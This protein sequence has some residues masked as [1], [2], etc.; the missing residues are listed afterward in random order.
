[1]PTENDRTDP[2]AKV[3]C[4][5]CGKSQDEVRKI[6]A[7]P[8]VYICDECINLCNDVMEVEAGTAAG[9]QRDDPKYSPEPT[10]ATKSTIWSLKRWVRSRRDPMPP[11][12]DAGQD[13]KEIQS[14]V[15]GLCGEPAP[16]ADV[17]L[18]RDRWLMCPTC[19][20]DVRKLILGE[21]SEEAATAWLAQA[22][23]DLAAARHMAAH[24]NWSYVLFFAHEVVEKALKGFLAASQTPHS[25]ATHS[26][27]TLLK[28][29]SN[30]DQRFQQFGPETWSLDTCYY[31]ARYPIGD[32]PKRAKEFFN[33]PE[34]GA[35]AIRTAEA[36]LTLCREAVHAILQKR[37]AT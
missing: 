25:R 21:T 26:V 14:K 5:F 3:V 30:V 20:E 37:P 16:L 31:L 6:I 32:P 23:D 22:E 1:M 29:S 19:I 18:V 11:M 34:E 12:P 10:P 7:G 36:V 24:D 17:F 8:A 28:W 4:S 15:C 33:N 27:F 2:A 35:A 13:A 9:S